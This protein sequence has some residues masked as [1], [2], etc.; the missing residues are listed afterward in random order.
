MGFKDEKKDVETMMVAEFT[1]P[2]IKELR[3]NKGTIVRG[4]VTVK[5]AEYYGF[6]WGVERAVR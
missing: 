1:S 5:L 2:L 4:D 3:D 6:C